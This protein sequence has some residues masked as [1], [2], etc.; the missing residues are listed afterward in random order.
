MALGQTLKY[1]TFTTPNAIIINFGIIKLSDCL[2]RDIR[3]TTSKLKSMIND[4]IRM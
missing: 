2:L 3:K 4:K 1:V